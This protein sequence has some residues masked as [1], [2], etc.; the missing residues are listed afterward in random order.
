M[1]RSRY[2]TGENLK[3]VRAVFNSDLSLILKI[4]LYEA[5]RG[6]A[7]TSQTEDLSS[8]L[9]IEYRK[10]NNNKKGNI[11]ICRPHYSVVHLSALQ[12]NGS[13]LYL[14]ELMVCRLI[15]PQT[16]L[17]QTNTVAPVSR[18]NCFLWCTGTVLRLNP[19]LKIFI[20]LSL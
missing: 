7:I 18:T 17:L 10:I 1:L 19:K 13:I 11:K 20:Q 16:F 5:L 4:F 2:L 8:I 14:Y 15:I 3:A 6:T 12:T 9:L